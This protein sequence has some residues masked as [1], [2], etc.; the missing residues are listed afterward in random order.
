[1]RTSSVNA[2]RSTVSAICILVILGCGSTVRKSSGSERWINIL[3]IP[4]KFHGE[5][6]GVNIIKKDG[7]K[8]KVENNADLITFAI[9][10]K[11]IMPL[12][13]PEA[14]WII[15]GVQLNGD[16]NGVI[17]VMSHT[18]NEPKANE[19]YIVLS[20]ND[21]GIVGIYFGEMDLEDNDANEDMV[22]FEIIK[23]ADLRDA[24]KDF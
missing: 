2:V 5:Y 12:M 19:S 16:N 22:G 9:G 24:W 6:S 14:Y 21:A 11:T 1:M 4:D 20:I 15:S 23:K 3:E 7:T 18:A 10:G 13:F 8:Q 17:R